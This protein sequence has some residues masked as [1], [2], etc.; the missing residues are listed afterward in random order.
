MRASRALLAEYVPE[1]H[2]G[3]GFGVVSSADGGVANAALTQR[4][5]FPSMAQWREQGG[6]E[7]S[8]PTPLLKNSKEF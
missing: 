6:Y 2:D 7:S 8:A 1:R 4:L 3:R 5:L